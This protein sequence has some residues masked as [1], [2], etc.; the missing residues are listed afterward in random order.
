MRRMRIVFAAV[1]VIL[2]IL[3]VSLFMQAS[4]PAPNGPYAVGRTDALLVDPAR[5]DMATA[6]AGDRREVPVQ[7][8]YPGVT[9]T[10]EAGD[11]FPGLDRVRDGLRASGEVSSFELL[12]LPSIRS[13]EHANAEIAGNPERFPL[14]VFSPG[15]GTNVE[16]Y[17]ALADELASCGYVVVGLNHSYDV[18]AVALAGGE[19]AVFHAGPDANRQ[20]YVAE[21]VAVRA[22]DILFVLR[23][24]EAMAAAGD[25]LMSRLDFG[26]VAVLGHSLGGIAAA[27]ACLANERIRA[28]GNFDGLQ[29]GGPFAVVDLITGPAQ[30]FLYLSKEEELPGP[31]MRLFEERVEPT[32]TVLIPEAE[33]DGFT[34][35]PLLQPGLLPIA[36]AADRVQALV[37]S[38]TLNFLAAALEGRPLVAM[39]EAGARAIVYGNPNPP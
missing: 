38:A 6:E 24:L 34:D 2:I 18:A 10:G 1:A 28:C 31:L 25:P 33:H 14:V 29:Q 7:I 20:S 12:G 8:W 4:L 35:A 16:F 5:E 39:R 13:A 32:Y 15:N 37:R 26:R 30:P 3:A 21:R 23:E 11:Y 36:G 9:G 19:V 27:Q 17:A 22:E